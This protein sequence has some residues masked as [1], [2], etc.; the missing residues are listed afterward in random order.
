[1]AWQ[2][3]SGD[4]INKLHG[5]YNSLTHRMKHVVANFRKAQAAQSKSEDG[6]AKDDEGALPAH[7]NLRGDPTLQKLEPMLKELKALFE[8]TSN[9]Q[10][11][12]SEEEF[13][14]A[15]APVFVPDA[16]KEELSQWFNS[17]DY[18]ADG[19]VGWDEF[20]SFLMA[21]HHIVSDKEEG[22]DFCLLPTQPEYF[23]D[24]HK[25]CI[26]H[27]LFNSTNDVYYS[28]GGD[29]MVKM[30]T[31]A[32]NA[33]PKVIHGC[34]P[35]STI[36][37][38]QWIPT[39]NR[40][41]I[42][43][44]DRVAAVYD[45]SML[46]RSPRNALLRIFKG[47]DTGMVSGKIDKGR[48]VA[49]R[50]VEK[51]PQA[52]R[53]WH[54][55]APRQLKKLKNAEGSVSKDQSA[56][57]LVDGIFGLNT[58]AQ[59]HQE[60]QALEATPLDELSCATMCID[61]AP[62]VMGGA[63]L[64]GTETGHINIY[65][66]RRLDASDDD[67]TNYKP[68]SKWKNH[69][70][71]VNKV[72]AVAS[73]N[74]FISCSS[75][76]TIQVFNIEKEHVYSQMKDSTAVQ[77]L[78][79]FSRRENRG[80]YGFDFSS[81][82]N[83]LASWGENRRFIVWNPL[84]ATALFQRMEHT[85]P[86]K[87]VLFKPNH[88]LLSLSEDKT[89]KIWDTRTFRCLQTI[90]DKQQR[91]PEDRFRCLAWDEKRKTI[92]TGSSYPVLYRMRAVK[93]QIEAGIC[94]Q[95]QLCGHL[96]PVNMVLYNPRF[97]HIISIDNDNMFTWDIK[98]GRQ[99]SKWCPDF[100]EGG[101]R[102]TA[103]C[104]GWRQRRLVTCADNGSVYMLNTISCT[105]LRE[106]AT[107]STDELSSCLSVLINAGLPH[108][109][110]LIFVAGFSNKI[111][112]FKDQEGLELSDSVGRPQHTL[113]MDGQGHA[114]CME[115]SAPSRLLVGSQK[116]T[117][118]LYNLNNMSLLSVSSG[119]SRMGPELQPTEVMRQVAKCVRGSQAD[120]YRERPG[121]KAGK[122]KKLVERV[123]RAMGQ[124]STIPGASSFV[125]FHS[126]T[127]KHVSANI[128][129]LTFLNSS[130]VATLHG[131]G[132]LCMWGIAKDTSQ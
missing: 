69:S 16:S 111:L 59:H 49:H 80:V 129:Y 115:F 107:G 103:A 27:M 46:A 64:L 68:A 61:F 71:Y 41:I 11:G 128:E 39:M 79:G 51:N 26:T 47:V 108:A 70:S 94:I 97:G 14:E 48:T 63:Y 92:V 74:G 121:A 123:G 52:M 101:H 62:W 75:D 32:M 91:L 83:I 58:D 110:A 73:L 22:N 112:V 72:L 45:C 114:Q 7:L 10:V 99:V 100:L 31:P 43:Q 55:M 82:L 50:L 37:D 84:T 66:T 77:L 76:E 1:M 98:T 96:Q 119:Y 126:I 33:P 125:A 86:I 12:V 81:E 18:D 19:N 89:V 124:T 95:K 85:H 53:S 44:L 6:D 102:I 87:Q 109:E 113:Y 93:D 65:H 5:V 57:D 4:V 127:Q 117:L 118:L 88:Q 90:V 35:G 9:G 15:F 13:I 40:L 28:A 130:L 38:M 67:I 20:C 106:Y 54:T 36:M 132:E 78:H 42:L 104:L 21:S 105:T 24:A 60:L 3:S 131:N 17:I 30:W 120:V 122:K 56:E 34:P 25:D 23:A 116:G 2:E 8:S 29:G